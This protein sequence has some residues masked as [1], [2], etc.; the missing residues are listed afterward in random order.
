MKKFVYAAA[1]FL[2][3]SGSAFAQDADDEDEEEPPRPGGSKVIEEL[4]KGNS[5][6]ERL[7]LFTT[8]ESAYMDCRFGYI[9]SE[10]HF[11]S[12]GK[13]LC[14]SPKVISMV[15]KRRG[16]FADRVKKWCDIDGR[17]K[18]EWQL[19]KRA[20]DLIKKGRPSG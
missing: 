17:M 13:P 7:C 16:S 20:R 12:H 6:G 10:T 19:I 4:T 2:A 14:S 5:I 9:L 15:N 18:R 1:V 11:Q 8:T 3:I